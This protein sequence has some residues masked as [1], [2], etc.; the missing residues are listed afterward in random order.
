ME[1]KGIGKSSPPTAANVDSLKATASQLMPNK[2]K[3]E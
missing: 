1:G 2:V 3:D